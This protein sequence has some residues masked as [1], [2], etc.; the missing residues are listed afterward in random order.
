MGVVCLAHPDGENGARGGGGAFLRAHCMVGR[1][2]G[3][4]VRLLVPCAP[5]GRG[6]QEEADSLLWLHT[7]AAWV[8]QPETCR[9]CGKRGFPGDTK[10]GVARQREELLPVEPTITSLRSSGARP[11]QALPATEPVLGTNPLSSI[12]YHQQHP[13]QAKSGHVGPALTCQWLPP[14]SVSQGLQH[15]SC[16][17]PAL[18]S[19]RSSLRAPWA[20]H[21]Y[22]R[23]APA[24]GSTGCSLCLKRSSQ[25]WDVHLPHL[26]LVFTQASLPHHP[27]PSASPLPALVFSLALFYLLYC[28]LPLFIL[29]TVCLS[30][31][32]DPKFHMERS[33]L[34]FTTVFQQPELLELTASTQS[35][36]ANRTEG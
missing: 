14:Q 5:A 21:G 13:A 22:S 33:S 27:D 4:S 34:L 3:G 12:L 29:L 31:L 32:P 2:R 30:S 6:S 35:V 36:F 15:R 10:P 17:C 24:S 16:H 7:Q 19:P 18:Q 9:V 8:V 11:P 25:R 26:L 23:L 28:V 20:L 1:Q